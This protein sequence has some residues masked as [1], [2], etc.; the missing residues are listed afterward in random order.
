MT[1]EQ[2]ELLAESRRS[3]AAAE[4]LVREAYYGYA[5]SRAYYAMFYVAQ[6]ALDALGLAFRKHSAVIAAFGQHLAGTGVVSTDLHRFLIEGHALRQVGDY[7]MAVE[8][9]EEQAELQ[10]TRAR[11]FIADAERLLSIAES[12]RRA[13]EDSGKT[14]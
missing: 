3:V 14:R 5:A 13:N 2:S 12:L 11:A 9:T 10:I 7:G 1:D 8:I 4:L 6:A